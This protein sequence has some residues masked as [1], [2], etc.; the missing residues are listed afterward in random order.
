[1]IVDASVVVKWFV[2]EPLH[3]EARALLLLDTELLAPDLVAVEVANALWLKVGRDEI[4]AASA[5][6]VIAAVAGGGEP[7]LRPSTPLVPRAFDLA[8]Q[9][10]HPAY[11]CVY[12]ALSEQLDLPVVTADTRLVDAASDAFGDRVL[13]LGG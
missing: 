13:L 6:R 5:R 2:A 4:E 11:D 1:M 12:L 8:R 3:E 10:D 7:E 9:L